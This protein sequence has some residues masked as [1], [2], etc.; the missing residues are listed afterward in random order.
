MRRSRQK[1]LLQLLKLTSLAHLKQRL[2]VR[3]RKRMTIN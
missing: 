1:L 3:E 2:E